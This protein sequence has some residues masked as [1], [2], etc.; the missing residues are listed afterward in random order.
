MALPAPEDI[1]ARS[2][3]IDPIPGLTG[4][5]TSPARRVLELKNLNAIAECRHQ[6]GLPITRVW[7]QGS[8]TLTGTN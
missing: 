2:G 6:N 8:P 4:I 3:G 1:A 5:E 7:M